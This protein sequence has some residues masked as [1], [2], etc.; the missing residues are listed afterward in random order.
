MSFLSGVKPV[1]YDCCIGSC[2]CYTGHYSS[3]RHCPYYHEPRFD[4]KNKA[5]HQFQYIPIIPRLVALYTNKEHSK[6]LQTY[7]ADFISD[8]HKVKDVFDGIHY[9][10]LLH[11][12]VTIHSKKLG[13]KFF[14]DMRNIALG[15]L[16][17]GFAPFKRCQYC[18]WSIIIFLYNLLPEI[19]FQLE[20]IFCI[21]EIPGSPKDANSFI[22]LFVEEIWMVAAGVR[23]YD[24]LHNQI[25]SLHL[26]LILGFGDIPAI[27]KLL[28]M[29]GHNSQCPCRMCSIV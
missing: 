13:R 7:C 18:S 1:Q 9:K 4:C 11:T 28:K 23:A 3:L 19:C 27:A 10:K 24:I 16:F 2:M 26:Y 20:N 22:Y 25:F 21:G 8:P 6:L 5:R 12:F 29:K 17:D 15:I 14:S